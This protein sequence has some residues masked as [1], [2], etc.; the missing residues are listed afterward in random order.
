VFI[1]ET[2]GRVKYPAG[3]QFPT[4]GKDIVDDTA[5]DIVDEHVGYTF[6]LL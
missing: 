5:K 4:T 1:S 6:W 2:S 3:K